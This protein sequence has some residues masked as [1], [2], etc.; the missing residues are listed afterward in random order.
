MGGTVRSVNLIDCRAADRP[1]V[2]AFLYRDCAAGI[3]V[4]A[5]DSWSDAR[6]R[7][8]DLTEHLDEAPL[9]HA[10]WNWRN[11]SDRAGDENCSIVALERE[12]EIQ[13]LMLV[14]R[15]LKASRHS[16]QRIV[17]VDFL[18]TAPWNLRLAGTSPRYAGVG[19]VLIA[20][21]V[22]LSRQLSAGGRIGLHSLPQAE[23]FY[24]R[25]GMTF[26]GKDP[27]YHDLGY[28]EFGSE[29]AKNW[30]ES[31]GEST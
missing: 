16:N 9:E 13:G 14:L 6:R 12:S 17:Y 1:L 11:K 28:Y 10:H 8:R 20:D 18:E 5:E 2:A 31:L 21:A 23:A 29:E 26:L 27:D 3:L 25:I 7:L 4:S 22:R 30:L 15:E 24:S 19:T